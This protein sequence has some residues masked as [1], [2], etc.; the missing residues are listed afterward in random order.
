MLSIRKVKAQEQYS[1]AHRIVS[2]LLFSITVSFPKE[3]VTDTE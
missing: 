3:A 2:K 1:E